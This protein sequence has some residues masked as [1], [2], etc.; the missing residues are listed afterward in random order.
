MRCLLML[1]LCFLVPQGVDAGDITRVWLTHRSNDPSR[2]VVNWMTDVPGESV[3]RFG[4]MGNEAETVR[5]DEQTT[6]H[7]VEIP[8]RHRDATYQY[9]VQTGEQQSAVATFKACPTDVLRVAVVADWHDKADL[10]AILGDDVHLLLT[11]GD[12]ISNTWRACGEGQTD[13]VKPYAALVDAYPELFRSTPFMPVL[14]N[15]DREM[16]PRGS[17]PPAEPV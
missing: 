2:I 8:L 11:A 6:L 15:H 4:L 9:S 1:L 5:I 13:C 7:H 16:R 17:M 3:V 14:G 12:N 10:T